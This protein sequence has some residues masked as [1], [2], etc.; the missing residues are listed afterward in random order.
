MKHGGEVFGKED[1]SK[2][3]INISTL[4][5]M[6]QVLELHFDKIFCPLVF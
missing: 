6:L 3:N 4:I 1:E 5:L 2:D